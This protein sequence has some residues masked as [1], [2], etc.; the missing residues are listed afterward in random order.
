MKRVE[1]SRESCII[2]GVC[3]G[4]GEYFNI[5]PVIFRIA[6]VVLALAKGVG[7]IAYVIAWIAIPRRPEGAV[8]DTT[9]PKS[10]FVKYLPGLALILIGVV[11][12][13]ED[14]F[15][16]FSI[17]HLWP[18]ILIVVGGVMVFAAMARRET[19]VGERRES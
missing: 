10:E 13:L 4:L 17:S 16:W 19:E 2:G 18:L 9:P 14:V 7:V 11:F 15:Y 8:A 1:R 6:A 12:L 5:D 3:G